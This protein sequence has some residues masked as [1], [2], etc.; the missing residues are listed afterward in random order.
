MIR[1][2]ISSLVPFAF[3]RIGDWLSTFPGKTAYAHWRDHYELAGSPIDRTFIE[4]C[5]GGFEQVFLLGSLH[6]DEVRTHYWGRLMATLY[7]EKQRGDLLFGSCSNTNLKPRMDT[8]RRLR[9]GQAIGQV[10]SSLEVDGH[11]TMVEEI[12][13]P[14]QSF[15]DSDIHFAATFVPLDL[16]LSAPWP[17]GISPWTVD[18]IRASIYM[19]DCA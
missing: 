16:S 1:P 18:H 17:S 7:G 12:Y 8:I 11:K 6:D 10:I 19:V 4:T 5:I 9:G 14:L 3:D 13:L 2:Q 15:Q